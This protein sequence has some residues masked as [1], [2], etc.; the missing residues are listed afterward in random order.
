M[1]E[2]GGDSA[3]KIAIPA[4]NTSKYTMRRVCEDL[5]F[6][7]PVALAYPGELGGAAVQNG[8]DMLERGVQFP[9]DTPELPT[10]THLAAYV[11]AEARLCLV[12][13]DDA[14]ATRGDFHVFHTG[15]VFVRVRVG[16]HLTRLTSTSR[17]TRVPRSLSTEEIADKQATA[18]PT[19]TSDI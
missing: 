1:P 17:N 6:E 16:H 15:A 10:L 14:R 8:T 4:P 12:D 13:G 7:Y 3:A 11:E 2:T 18:S 5:H 19:T 9:V